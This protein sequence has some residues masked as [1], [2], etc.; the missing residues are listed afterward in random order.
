M[1][2]R[3]SMHPDHD[4]LVLHYY[5]EAGADAARIEQHLAGCAACRTTRARLQQTLALVEVSDEGEPAPGYEATVWARLQ[6]Q[7]DPPAPWWRLGWPGGVARWA[8]AGA[9]ATVATVAFYAG[10]QLR[11]EAPPA[12]GSTAA[13][14]PVDPSYPATGDDRTRLLDLAVGD[15]LDRVQLMLSEVSNSY[16]SAAAPLAAERLRAG[17]M[18]AA[19]RLFRQT[20][21]L[22]GDD[23]LDRVLDELERVLVEIA[24]APDGVGTDDWA[25]LK[26]RLDTQDLLFR[27][28]VI[29][30][31]RRAR[32][33]PATT[34]RKGPT[35]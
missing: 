8:V 26:A 7:L 9:M 22:T 5:G 32:Q 23:S 33:R 12:T 14:T 34:L 30:D 19:N 17:D 27:V 13:A 28:R 31:E 3:T 16:G 2:S 20:A 18:V 29:T 4:D 21:A 35:S 15:H 25:A 10:W 24:N 6:G 11:D 1:E